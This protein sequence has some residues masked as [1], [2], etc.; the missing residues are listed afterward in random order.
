MFGDIFENLAKTVCS[1]QVV[2]VVMMHRSGLFPCRSSWPDA[3]AVVKPRVP[4]YPDRSWTAET[5]LDLSKGLTFRLITQAT[6]LCQA[7]M[8]DEKLQVTK[9]DFCGSLRS[10]RYQPR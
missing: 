8:A 1:V 7:G 3:Q 2:S 10:R 5:G 6:P 9:I 4:H